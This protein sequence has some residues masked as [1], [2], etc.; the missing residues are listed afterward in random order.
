MGQKNKY[1]N[2]GLKNDHINNCIKY[3]YSEH[4]KSNDCPTG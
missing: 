4:S 2:D 1:Q 3:K